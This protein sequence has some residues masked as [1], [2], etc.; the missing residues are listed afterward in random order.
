MV[1]A[2]DA[3]CSLLKPGGAL[4]DLRPDGNP[5]EFWGYKGE[6]PILLGHLDETDDYVEYR[7]AAQAMEKAIENRW[8]QPQKRGEFDFVIHADS[9][10]EM[11]DYLTTEWTDAVIPDEVWSN[12]RSWEPDRVA[13]REVVHI[14][15]LQAV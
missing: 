1:H 9:L 2:L 12:V 4:I 11:R 14:G 15:I 8:F 6:D 10:E 13:L 5:A 7:Q 3:I